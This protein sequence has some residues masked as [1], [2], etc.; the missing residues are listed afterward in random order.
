M[1]TPYELV[2]SPAHADRHKSL[3]VSEGEQTDLA[4]SAD[5]FE[6]EH[7]QRAAAHLLDNDLPLF[8]EVSR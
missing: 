1:S 4:D 5:W 2:D 3:S 8:Q 6:R 7:G